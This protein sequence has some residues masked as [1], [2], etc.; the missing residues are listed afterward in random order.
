MTK[1]QQ[2]SQSTIKPEEDKQAS[3]VDLIG[4]TSSFLCLL[5]CIAVPFVLGW[6]SLQDAHHHHHHASAASHQ[7]T[8]FQASMLL[9]WDYLFVIICLVAVWSA[10]RKAHTTPVLKMMLWSFFALFSVGILMEAVHPVFQYM[11]YAAS[12]GLIWAH[13]RNYRACQIAH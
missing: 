3:K 12:A 8:H 4:M 2:A 1:I 10:S 13:W 11:G 6:Y 5:H 9:N 7:H